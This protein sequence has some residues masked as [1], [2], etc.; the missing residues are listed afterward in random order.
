MVTGGGPALDQ[1]IRPP[2]P[3]YLETCLLGFFAYLAAN[4]VGILFKYRNN[5][6]YKFIRPFVITFTVYLANADNKYVT[7]HNIVWG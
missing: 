3:V 2:Y 1:N 6:N 5:N 7:I 4:F